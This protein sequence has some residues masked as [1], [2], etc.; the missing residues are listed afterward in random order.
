MDG[1]DLEEKSAFKMLGLTFPSK[2]DLGFYIASVVKTVSKKIGALICSM[3]L[4]SPEAAL[5][6]YQSTIR[7]CKEYSCH[8]LAGA[9]SYCLELLDAVRINSYLLTTGSS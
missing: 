9:P 4:F 6:L 5:Y 7:P 1:S 3:K 2:L 8:V